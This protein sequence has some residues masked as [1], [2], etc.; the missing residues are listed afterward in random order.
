MQDFKNTKDFRKTKIFDP[1]YDDP[2]YLSF[3]FMFDY[4]TEHSPLLNGDAVSYLKNVIGDTKRAESLENF[5]KI[6]KKVNSEYPWFWQSFS[7]LETAK[8]YGNMAD[9]YWEKIKQLT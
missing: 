4:Y 3:F 1:I 5:I 6:L 2:T 8:Q 9:P 7:G